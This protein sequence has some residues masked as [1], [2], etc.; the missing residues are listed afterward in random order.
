MSNFPKILISGAILFCAFPVMTI[1]EGDIGG[2][3][4]GVNIYY[5]ILLFIS[6]LTVYFFLFSKKSEYQTIQ[7]GLFAKDERYGIILS[8]LLL[9]SFYACMSAFLNPV[10]F[11]GID[12]ISPRGGMGADKSALQFSFSNLGQAV[13]LAA[14]VAFIFFS[15]AEISSYEAF[16]K[17]VIRFFDITIYV[18]IIMSFWQIVSK[19]TGIYF[20]DEVL[21]NMLDRGEA[22]QTISG[23]HRIN[24]P[25]R[26]P[27]DLGRIL[28]SFFAFSSIA[29]F[30][31]KSKIKYTVLS[32]VL[33]LLIFMSTS[34]VGILVLILVLAFFCLMFLYKAVQRNRT[35]KINL[36]YVSVVCVCLL[37]VYALF[38]DQVN[39][40]ISRSILEKAGSDSFRVRLAADTFSLHV[41]TETLMLGAGLGSNRP[42]GFLAY[43]LSNTGIIGLGLFLS[44]IVLLGRSYLAHRKEDVFLDLTFGAFTT[45]LVA[46]CIA[47]PDLSTE[48]FWVFF[49]AYLINLN[50]VRRHG[51]LKPASPGR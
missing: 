41:A 16:Q 1:G 6:V 25:M 31:S 33:V 36:V 24:G 37:V 39:Q 26:E 9:F 20:P 8:V 38:F 45:C 22:N 15:I 17:Y 48:Y 44:M 28:V 23:F 19:W 50:L 32:V 18:L 42:S 49:A 27:S 47:G 21:F 4:F 43:L 40:I 11:E 5:F 7:S 34:S 14:N 10:I 30:K 29:A 35:F 46:K 3:R 13:Y 2:F 51:A 12:V